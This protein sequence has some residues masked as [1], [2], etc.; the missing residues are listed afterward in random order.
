MPEIVRSSDQ[1]QAARAE[2]G[3]D[4]WPTAKCPKCGYQCGYLFDVEVTEAVMVEVQR[5]VTFN[6]TTG[7]EPVEEQ[8]TELVPE[9]RTRLAPVVFDPGCNCE[10]QKLRERRW[11]AI[12]QHYAREAQKNPEAVGAMDAFWGFAPL[13]AREA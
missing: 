10:R 8:I 4:S 5:T 9:Q 12:A 6:S 13:P 2:R 3:I 11:D 1:F 7:A